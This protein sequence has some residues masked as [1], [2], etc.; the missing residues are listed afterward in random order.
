MTQV[1]HACECRLAARASELGTVKRR[2]PK[3]TLTVSG[4]GVRIPSGAPLSTHLRTL[5]R[6]GLTG[7][8]GAFEY[9]LAAFDADLSVVDFDDI[10]E[11]LQIRLPERHR[12]SGEL[13]AHGAAEALDQR[14]INLD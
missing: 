10:D 13:F 7:Q 11:R 8:H 9:V 2:T 1:A 12:A 4:P 6:A 14:R 5:G 3:R